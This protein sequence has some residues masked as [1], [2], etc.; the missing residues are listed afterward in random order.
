[1]RVPRRKWV[2]IGALSAVAGMAGPAWA[3]ETAAIGLAIDAIMALVGVVAAAGLGVSL[4][5]L[6]ADGRRGRPLLGML[7]TLFAGGL[8][9]LLLLP[10]QSEGLLVI[11]ALLMSGLLLIHVSRL[12]ARG[13]RRPLTVRGSASLKAHLRDLW[14]HL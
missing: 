10:V 9:M 13:L 11:A 4:F 3:E 6:G 2:I 7:A 1:M 14:R 5:A 12:V 8:L